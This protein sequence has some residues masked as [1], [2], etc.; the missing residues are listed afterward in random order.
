MKSKVIS[1]VEDVYSRLDEELPVF[2]RGECSRCGQC[3][4]FDE[5]DHRLFVT[6]PEMIYFRSHINIV[7]SGDGSCPWQKE[8]RCTVYEHR[9]SGCRIYSCRADPQQQGS[10]SEKVLGEF[11]RICDEF[12]LEYRYMD[13]R[14][15]L[16]LILT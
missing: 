13:L 15:F 3:C 7:P 10:L 12:D 5:F 16:S 14:D 11:R 1:L 6:T 4:R 2:D 8:G 9:F